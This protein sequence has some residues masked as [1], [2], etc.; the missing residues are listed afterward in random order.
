VAALPAMPREAPSRSVQVAVVHFAAGS[1]ELSA[2]DLRSIADAVALH[3]KYGGVVRVIGHASSRT[4]NMDMLQHKLVNFDISVRR[5]QAVAEE[6]VRRGV[7]RDNILV[8]AAS[9]NEPVFFEFMPAGEA[10]N[11]RAEIYLD[12]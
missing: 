8:M 7:K 2:A 9:D 1:A 12:Y 4:G 10:G 6:L 5:A 11:R 3:K